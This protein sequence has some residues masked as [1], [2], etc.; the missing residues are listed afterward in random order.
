MCA[1]V[2]PNSMIDHLA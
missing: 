1:Y 2:G